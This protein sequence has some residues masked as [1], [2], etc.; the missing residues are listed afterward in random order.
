LP[1]FHAST[2]AAFSWSITSSGSFSWV[3]IHNQIDSDAF[4]KPDG[5]R[6]AFAFNKTFHSLA[7]SSQRAQ[8]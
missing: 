6:T 2:A 5:L 7:P 4:W 3:M 8:N 1:H